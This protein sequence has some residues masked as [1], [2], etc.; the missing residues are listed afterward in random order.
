[1]AQANGAVQSAEKARQAVSEQ[2]PASESVTSANSTESGWIDSDGEGAMGPQVSI[3]HVRSSIKVEDPLSDRQVSHDHVLAKFGV[4][5]VS[6]ARLGRLDPVV[7]RD[8]EIKRAL[9]ILS[10][11]TKNNVCLIGEPGVG[12]T[13]LVEAIA[14]R[15]ADGRVPEQL[16]YCRELWS[17]DVGALLAGT[18][19]RGDFEERLRSVL[20]EVRASK[21]AILLFID[22][23]HLVLGAGRSES[24]NVD[25][26]NL[27]KPMLARGEI[28]CIGATT[29]LEYQQL[30]LAKDA[31][32]ERRFQPLELREPSLAV[33]IEMLSALAP[34]YASHHEVAISSEVIQSVVHLSNRSI[35]GRSFPDKAIDV[36]DEACCFATARGYK[37][38]TQEHVESVLK[39]WRAPLWQRQPAN[40]LVEWLKHSWSRL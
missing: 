2:G 18:G 1:M 22:E 17:L 12:K 11:R 34:S 39:Q 28:H 25:A 30:I 8:E 3:D 38:V 35:V 15:I 23:L 33:A 5:M 26:A 27:M 37:A 20:A 32:F 29:T 7:G 13:A 24:N 14:Q 10:R 19:L 9:Q 6:Q 40:R 21:G 4:D 16:R 36:L 31:A